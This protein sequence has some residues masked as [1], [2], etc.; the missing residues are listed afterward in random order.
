M[1]L[2]T[3]AGQMMEWVVRL[4]DTAGTLRCLATTFSAESDRIAADLCHRIFQCPMGIR[5]EGISEA[6]VGFSVANGRN[7]STAAG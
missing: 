3:F 6:L 4:F 1:T 2:V 7:L 5:Y